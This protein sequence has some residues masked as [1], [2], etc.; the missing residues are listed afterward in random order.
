[1]DE[2]NKSRS[3]ITSIKTGRERALPAMVRF[4]R[5]LDEA[6][7]PLVEA[8]ACKTGCSYCCHYHVYIS[9][10]EAFALAQYVEILSASDRSAVTARLES[11]NVLIRGMTV[12]E[13]IA[14]NVRCAFLSDTGSCLAYSVIGAH[15]HAQALLGA[16]FARYELHGAVHEAMTNKGSQKRWRDG[17]TAFPSVQDRD[18]DSVLG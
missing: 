18:L 9:A 1:M 6:V 13:H 15:L 10:P 12:D 16:D 7:K 8:T 2:L 3:D 5:R 17:K 4:Y 14:T 11:N